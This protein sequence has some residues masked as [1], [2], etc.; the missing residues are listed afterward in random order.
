M[1][2]IK[3][4]PVSEGVALGIAT[5]IEKE[6]LTIDR[7]SIQPHEIESEL[8]RFGIDVN[9]VIQEIEDLIENYTFNQDHKDILITQ[10]MILQDPEFNKRVTKQIQN[11]LC[12]LE[13]AIS[14]YFTEIA[15]I[16]SNMDNEFFAQRVS[17]YEDV[18]YRLLS[19]T[20]KQ[21]EQLL[22]GLDEN[23]ILIM[24]NITPSFVTKV[25]KKKI[26]GLI[27]EKGS[28]NSH[29]SIIARS[30]GLPMIVG[31]REI[32]DNIPNGT[33]LIIDG[34]DGVIYLDPSNEI[35][36]K[37]DT[38]FAKEQEYKHELEKLIDVKPST[39]DGKSVRLMS[40]I[41]IPD[42][43]DRVVEF[44][45]EGI[46]LFR[47]EFLFIDKNKL[48]TEEEQYQIYKK[49]A[50][51]IFPEPLVIRTIDVGG[52]KLSSIL[53]LGREENPNLGCRGIR[54]S[55][56][57]VPIFKVQIRAILRANMKGNIKIMFPMIS[58]VQ[59][60]IMAKKIIAECMDYLTERDVEFGEKLE[61]GAMIE[62]PSAVITSDALARNC[63]F[64]SIGTND[65]VQY[66]LAVD[67]DNES[68]SSYY[69]SCHPSVLRSIKLTTDNAHKCG[70]K[71]TVC[72]EMASEPRYVQ[73]LLGLGVDELSVSP[74]RLLMIKN[75]II[76][77]D[78]HDAR[79]LADMALQ[80][81]STETITKLLDK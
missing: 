74:G 26:R 57:N 68:V 27:T 61:V 69:K 21:G 66:T 31:V 72:G 32:I 55:F 53:N 81:D 51:K 71:V 52:D 30:M 1:K 59:E 22:S 60:I 12:S 36:K 24:K 5:V 29:S 56:E 10:R 43:L 6:K 33:K 42:E 54:I 16:F 7:K 44:H 28:R 11:E 9:L 4:I 23:S 49:I 48:P 19:R 3:G 50:E 80:E 14:S 47:T 65:L 37:F 25:F 63:D 38:I 64:L 41:E 75:E 17:D 67:R 40:N 79:I 39:L 70:K 8:E 73:L 78:L 46:G 2:K 58:D 20:L 62:V 13:H 35:Q 77:C 18:A 15:K 34:S 76:K 45:S